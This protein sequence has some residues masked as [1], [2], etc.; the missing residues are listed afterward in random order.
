MDVGLDNIALEISAALL[1]QDAICM[2]K[3]LDTVFLVSILGK[4][5]IDR[6]EFAIRLHSCVRID[7]TLM[8][9]LGLVWR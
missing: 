4:Y 3:A 8:K 5:S 2:T 7:S 1:T 9:L 6:V